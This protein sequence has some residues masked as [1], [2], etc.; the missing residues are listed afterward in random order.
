MTSGPA[1]RT[2]LQAGGAFT[3]AFLLFRQSGKAGAAMSPRPQPSDAAAAA[4]D[5]HPAFAPN[6]FIRIDRTGPV[7]LVMPN[8]EM[9][10]G[11]YTAAATLIAE[12]LDVGL[13]Q[14]VIEHSPPNDALYATSLMGAQVT[15]GS[16]SV[17][18][19]WRLLREVGALARGMLVG[20]AAHRW[21]VDPAACTAEH[22]TVRHAASGRVASYADLAEAAAQQPVPAKLTLKDPKDFRLIGKPLRRL[23]SPGKVDGRTRF[24]I[25]VHVPGMLIATIVGCPIIGG[26]VQSVNDAAARAVPGVRDVVRLEDSV[27]VIG[28]H[29]WAAKTGADALFVKWEP[30]PNAE[31]STQRMMVAMQQASHTAKSLVAR[32]VGNLSQNG[33]QIEAVYQLPML[34]H[35]QM[36]PLNAVVHV[37]QDACEIWTGTQVPTRVVSAATAIT[38]LPN[39]KIILHNQYLGGGFGRRLETDAVELAIKVARQV[40]YPVKLV[41]TREHDIQHDIP[42]PAYHDRLTAT[43]NSDGFPMTWSD[44]ITGASVAR[45]WA[46]ASLRADGLDSDT[47]E[48]ADEPPYDLPNLKVEWVPF[49]LP[50]TMP[51][52]WWRGVGETHNLF[53][54]E[55]FID[56]LAHVAGKDP[57]EYRRVLLQKNPRVLGVLNIAADK[58]GWGA[59]RGPRIGRGVAVGSPFGSH[60]CAMVE[61]EVTPQG[62][63]RI[64]RTVVVVDCGL[65]INPNTV[66]SQIQGGLVFG[67][68]AALYGQLTY[69]GGA[70]QQSNFNDYRMMRINETPPIEVQIVSSTA[71]PG[72]IGEVGT[73]IAAPALVNAIFGA[74]GVRLRKLPIDRTLLVTKGDTQ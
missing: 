28:E 69:K 36:E 63:V 26:R 18:S 46:P 74:T 32:Q 43:V 52:G 42:R 56:E 71:D 14:V 31:F 58:L 60:V 73:A 8:V 7:R 12:E 20:A 2:V 54:V 67:W 66:E 33:K 53:T 40:P 34:A 65:V 48:G 4:A 13:D 30:G 17:R 45:R 11:I 5:G 25:D 9:G 57:V 6:A 21:N 62:D 23:D 15:G 39:E 55:S 64:R 37:R 3:L 47:T 51:V 35:A 16:A 61:V 19:N 59:P 29:F 24:G 44:R 38:G 41:L 49:D 22:G 70:A 50:A 10:Q 1:R 72:G 68:T 27:A